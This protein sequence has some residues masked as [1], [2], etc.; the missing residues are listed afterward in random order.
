M[1]VTRPAL[2]ICIH[3]LRFYTDGPDV[4]NGFIALQ[5]YNLWLPALHVYCSSQL[6]KNMRYHYRLTFLKLW[7]RVVLI[8]SNSHGRACGCEVFARTTKMI[9]RPYHSFRQR[10]FRWNWICRSV[11]NRAPTREIISIHRWLLSFGKS[12]CI[13]KLTISSRVFIFIKILKIWPSN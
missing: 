12:F 9:R 5:N 2:H 3:I 13:E 11:H 4:W 1:H 8:L 7:L 10:R 6:L